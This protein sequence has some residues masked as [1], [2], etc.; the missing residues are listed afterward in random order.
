MK[1][2]YH[3]ES[4]VVLKVGWSVGRGE[5]LLAGGDPGHMSQISTLGNIPWD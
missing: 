3:K 1:I 4:L 2:A 5:S